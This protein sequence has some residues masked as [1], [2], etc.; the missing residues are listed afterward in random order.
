MIRECFVFIYLPGKTEAIPAGKLTFAD[1]SAAFA[2]GNRYLQNPARIPVDPLLLPL[3]GPGRAVSLD[4]ER[5]GAIRD[6]AP[7]FWG[8]RVIEYARG[9]ESLPEIDYLLGE[10]VCRAGNLDF[11]IAPSTPESAFGPP[12]VAALE[13]LMYAA[14][15]IERDLPLDSI[16]QDILKL[17]EQGTS[18]GGAR[19]KTTVL[20]GQGL[21]IAKFPSRH[22]RWSNGR[23]EAATMLLAG[24]CG[25]RVPEMKILSLA[26]RD[27]FLIRRFDRE[28]EGRGWSRKGYMSGLS[29][30][31]IGEGERDRYSYLGL[32][33]RMR[34]HGLSGQLE[35]LF[36]RM[37]FNIICRNTDDHPRNHG[38]LVENESLSLS[39]AFDVTP[40]PCRPGVSTTAYQAM[41]VG[42]LG[43]REAGL[44]NAL[45]ACA[46]FGLGRG[47]A[48]RIIADMLRSCLG[49]WEDCFAR[50]GVSSGDRELFAHTFER[51]SI[52]HDD[53]DQVE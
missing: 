24:Q 28:S 38:F 17:L 46:R 5:L 51:W 19:P 7:D 42:T 50:H 26:G 14:E 44:D 41:I 40:T 10:N 18:I 29:L 23:V 36:K 43:G 20:D 52:N 45:S 27:V 48:E 34:Q 12:G 8:R 32:A 3:A 4:P 35:E 25:L 37:I 1:D 53:P 13:D 22:D 31:G 47:E 9:R 49:R 21:W 11:R 33:D 30:L 6:S 16:R 39:P 2:Y 15:A